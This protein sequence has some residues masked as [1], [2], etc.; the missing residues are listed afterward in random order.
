[1]IERDLDIR[2]GGDSA[3]DERVQLRVLEHVPPV[4]QIDGAG[5]G[6]WLLRGIMVRQRNLRLV[7]VG[8]NGAPSDR[9]GHRKDGGERGSAKPLAD[10]GCLATSTGSPASIWLLKL[11]TR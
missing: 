2:V 6:R 9:H 10:H 7:I 8:T 4:G 3:F 11:S 1:M 5:N